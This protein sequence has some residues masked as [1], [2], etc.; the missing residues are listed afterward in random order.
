M[1]WIIIFYL[2][3]R[4]IFCVY[5]LTSQ[6]VVCSMVWGGCYLGHT[7]PTLVVWWGTYPGV[8]TFLALATRLGLKLKYLPTIPPTAWFDV[9]SV[10]CKWENFFSATDRM[11]L[12]FTSHGW[13]YIW[14]HVQLL[15]TVTPSTPI[16]L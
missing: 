14:Q 3:N 4:R 9:I 15:T 2:Q 8:M 13:Y 6:I 11:H 10:L 1:Y 12:G 16:V 7:L 5:S